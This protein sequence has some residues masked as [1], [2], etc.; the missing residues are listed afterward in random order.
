MIEPLEQL[1]GRLGYRFTNPALCRQA[2]T[3]RSYGS[4]HNERLEFLGDAVLDLLISELL[5]LRFPAAS[6][7]ELSRMRAAVVCGEN[8]AGIGGE[9]ALGDCLLLG[10]GEA[11]SGGR[12]RQSSLANAVE[13][14]IA[15]VYLD[16]GMLA[17]STLVNKLFAAVL[18]QANPGSDKDPKSSLQEYLQARQ[19]AL[20]EYRLL[21]QSGADHNASFTMEC[22]VVRLGLVA[23][24][25]ASSRKKAEG[26]AAGKI[27][28]SLESRKH[29]GTRIRSK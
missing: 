20:P 14:L 8:L 11:A 5:F 28:E 12:Q 7:G 15:A 26:L 18:Q 19:L 1:Q 13:A 17:C 25:T 29:E 3:H 10:A 24:A 23:Q 27:L 22:A 16:G 2:L 4:L 21:C 9:L 6:E